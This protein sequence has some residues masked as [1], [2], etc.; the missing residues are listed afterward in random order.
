MSVTQWRSKPGVFFVRGPC[1]IGVQAQSRN[2]FRKPHH[3]TLIPPVSDHPRASLAE[4]TGLHGTAG[5][6]LR[7]G[8]R[9]KGGFRCAK[10][11]MLMP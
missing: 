8:Q 4:Y 1:T 6:R 10:E 11:D 2:R 7:R 3:R 5:V 9:R